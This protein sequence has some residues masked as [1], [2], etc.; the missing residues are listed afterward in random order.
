MINALKFVGQLGIPFKTHRNSD[1]LKPVSDIKDI[2]TLTK[3][4]RAISQL[5]SMGNTEFATQLKESPS[6]TTYLSPYIQN[7]LIT[8]F[9]EEIFSSISS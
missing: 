7:E 2:D 9:G 5:H 1:R 6:N 8:L 4:F 3:N